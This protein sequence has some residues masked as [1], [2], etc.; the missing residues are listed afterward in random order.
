VSTGGCFARDRVLRAALRGTRR[1]LL[2]VY[3]VYSWD[4]VM[5]IVAGRIYGASVGS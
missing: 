5:T 2:G 4:M 3:R 1:S